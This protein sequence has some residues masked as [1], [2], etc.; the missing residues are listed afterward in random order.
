MN[1]LVRLY[2]EGK[3][4]MEQA[5][6]C[7]SKNQINEA[8][9]LRNRAND[10]YSKAHKI[11]CLENTDRDKLYGKNRNFGICY[12][13]F[14]DSLLKNMKSRKGKK[15]I[16]EVSN[17]I[18]KDKILKKQFDVYN[19]IC[20]KS[21]TETNK[22]IDDIIECVSKMDVSKNDIKKSNDK[23]I[24]LLEANSNVNKL[25]DIDND[26][27]K[28]YED[29]EFI[30]TNKKT[31]NNID[32]FNT[33]K[34]SLS[35]SLSKIYTHNNSEVNEDYEKK[36][37]DITEKYEDITD[38]ELKLFEKISSKNTNKSNLFDAYKNETIDN[39]NEAINNASDDDRE[40]WQNIKT[41][42]DEKKYNEKTFVEDILNFVEIQKNL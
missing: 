10:V 26:T 15:F 38:D 1:D 4:L 40:Q 32:E 6:D 8:E 42:L 20:K 23:L 37:S 3:A 17:L 14:E 27:I 28:L 9:E 11:Y 16:N 12:H 22:Y 34:N 30:L 41:A 13:I 19:N 18:K 2:N 31:L 39:V 33:V 21:V 36:I 29:I 24:D 5:I 35:E 7:Y 25:L